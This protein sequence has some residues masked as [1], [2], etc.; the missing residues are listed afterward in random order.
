MN[1]VIFVL[2]DIITFGV[3][4][5]NL[6]STTVVEYFCQYRYKENLISSF[7]IH[8]IE[9]HVNSILFLDTLSRHMLIPCSPGARGFYLC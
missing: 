1:N 6:Y 9:I 4:S 8:I 7:I 2:S 3:L 5:Q